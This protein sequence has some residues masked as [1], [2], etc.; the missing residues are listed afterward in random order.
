MHHASL[1]VWSYTSIQHSRDAAE[2][3]DAEEFRTA[4]DSLEAR[5]GAVDLPGGRAVGIF[6]HEVIEKLDFESF[7][8]IPNLK[9]WAER[10]DVRELF[11][12][13]MRRSGVTD[14]RWMTR[15]PE[16]VFNA[17]TSRIALG[18]NALE[19][20]LYQLRNVRE[21]E[22]TYP[23]PER[24]H[25]L[26]ASAGDGA[27]V[28]ERGYVKGYID[29]VFQ[30]ADSIYFADWKGDLLPSY[31]P[32]AVT[33]HVDRHYGLQASIYALGIIRLLGIDTESDYNHR[34]GGLLY[35]FLRGVSPTGDGKSGLYFARPSWRE[36]VSYESALM[37]T[38][39]DSRNHP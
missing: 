22:F 6:L 23:I 35:V 10:E 12:K 21:M 9:S 29:L 30:H 19:H 11:A 8:D 34:F 26:L 33:G 5:T 28:V 39:V 27:W 1:K 17:L 36:I 14:S 16:V 31:D 4:M 2:P 13:T 18:E 3:F 20:G 32:A 7:G 37:T 25:R 24:H 15:G 38:N